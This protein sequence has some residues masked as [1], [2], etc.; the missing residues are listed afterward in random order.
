MQ[1]ADFAVQ[2]ICKVAHHLPSN[3]TLESLLR[4]SRREG[5]PLLTGYREDRTPSRRKV[6]VGNT[7]SLH[8]R[9]L[10]PRSPSLHLLLST[11]PLPFQR[12]IQCGELKTWCRGRTSGRG[13]RGYFGPKCLSSFGLLS[14]RETYRAPVA[15]ESVGESGVI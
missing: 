12:G 7:P 1:T 6:S 11:P 14:R 4:F 8:W 9:N 5:D 15:G 10:P 2:R 13:F 3:A